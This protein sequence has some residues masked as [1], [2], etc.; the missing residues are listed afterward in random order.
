MRGLSIVAV[1]AIVSQSGCI[2]SLSLPVPEP[3]PPVSTAATQPQPPAAAQASAEATTQRPA[4]DEP[5][6]GPA[7][8]A[9]IP[10]APSEP[11]ASSARTPA[12][13]PVAAAPPAD[14]PPTSAAPA[15]PADSAALDVAGLT[16]RLRDTNA[17]GVFTKLTLK[18]QVDDLLAQFRGVYEGDIEVPMTELRQRYEL[19]L[20]KVLTLLQDS[21]RQLAEAI[22]ASREAIWGILADPQRF[23]EI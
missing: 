8:A 13:V 6:P 7:T 10:A 22:T 19:L 17:M 2:Q 18:N 12:P 20:L 21:D 14:P 3:R 16:Q 5:R 9:P 4:A 1:T 15:D 11:A 23:A